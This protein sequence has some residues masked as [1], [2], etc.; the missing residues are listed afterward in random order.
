MDANELARIRD[1]ID[2]LLPDTA[3]ILSVTY[4]S[5]GYGGLTETWGTALTSACRIDP[6]N[7][8]EVL[9]GGAIQPY[10]AFQLT[11][12]HD[13]ALTTEER[14]KIGTVT[15][16]VKDVDNGKS[17]SASTRAVLEVV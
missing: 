4:V 3:Y 16:S 8:T 7:G 6:L 11:L 2:N 14:I 9:A 17:W 5:D 10:H 15:Y 12:P 13:T 1:D